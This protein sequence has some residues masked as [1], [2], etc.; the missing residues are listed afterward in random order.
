MDSSATGEYFGSDGNPASSSR[1]VALS[2]AAGESSSELRLQREPVAMSKVVHEVVAGLR[3]KF[4]AR[5]QEFVLALP[6]TE[7]LVDADEAR[8]MQIVAN[9]VDNATK[10]TADG[11]RLGL[12]LE[13]SA[14]TCTLRV[15]DEGIGIAS[16]DAERVLEMA[17]YHLGFN[18][19]DVEAV[20]VLYVFDL[21]YAGNHDEVVAE[22]L[23]ASSPL[24]SLVGLPGSRV[25]N[26]EPTVMLALDD[27]C[28]LQARLSI[29]TRTNAFQVRTGQFPEAPISVYFTVRQYWG[30][31]SFKSFVESYQNQRRV[32]DELV[33]QYVVPIV[34]TPL[35][36]VIGAKQ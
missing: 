27:P 34:I 3:P 4:E 28:R 32:L 22:A 25:I 31:Q 6:E 2:R 10:Y 20:D 15:W 26:Y 9:L 8:L 13:A 18:G 29:E 35:Q 5:R 33:T 30:R 7:V 1:R 24:E 12:T 36:K 14:T 16:N 23:T 21:A 11:G 19:L 17:P